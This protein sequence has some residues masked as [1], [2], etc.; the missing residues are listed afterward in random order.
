M[1]FNLNRSVL[2]SAWYFK[3]P[4]MPRLRIVPQGTTFASEKKKEG[5]EFLQRGE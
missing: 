4:V 1:D 5:V 3:P 2:T